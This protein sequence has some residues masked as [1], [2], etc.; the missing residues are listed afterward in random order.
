MK[1]ELKVRPP[2]PSICSRYTLSNPT[3]RMGDPLHEWLNVDGQTL[4]QNGFQDASEVIPQDANSIFPYQS[5]P[6]PQSRRQGHSYR[7][8]HQPFPETTP[9]F[10]R[11]QPPQT[12]QN[13]SF[14]VPSFP[15]TNNALNISQVQE[16]HAVPPSSSGNL[17]L[18]NLVP[19]DMMNWINLAEYNAGGMSAG[20]DNVQRADMAETTNPSYASDGAFSNLAWP[21]EM[22]SVNGISNGTG[23][24]AHPM[25]QSNHYQQQPTQQANIAVPHISNH[26]DMLHGQTSIQTQGQQQNPAEEC[27]K[28]QYWIQSGF[29]QIPLAQ[30]TMPQTVP[31]QQSASGLGFAS[32][33]NGTHPVPQ[34]QIK[35]IMQGFSGLGESSVPEN[36]Y[37]QGAQYLANP[38]SSFQPQPAQTMQPLPQN[39]TQVECEQF[40][41]YA[42]A[43]PLSTMATGTTVPRSDAYHHHTAVAGQLETLSL[44][45][46]RGNPAS[47]Q[48]L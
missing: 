6:A 10:S 37:P 39:P 23:H 13:A 30:S 48:I 40:L 29:P 32:N 9:Q 42:M 44:A 14:A 27:M 15:T 4:Y 17:G 28:L 3:S 11:Y 7:A 21:H 34:Q 1:A 2:A 45:Q 31:T 18:S 36:A 16:S 35:P 38:T 46:D 24:L 8:P 41:A 25:Q 26:N 43:G 20:S 47:G 19:Q 12:I 33:T 22:S 5:I